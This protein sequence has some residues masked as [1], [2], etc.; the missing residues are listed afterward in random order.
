MS[1]ISENVTNIN[2]SL[3]I[4][5]TEDELNFQSQFFQI[6][7]CFKKSQDYSVGD[8]SIFQ[9]NYGIRLRLAP[10]KDEYKIWDSLCYSSCNIHTPQQPHKL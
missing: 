7:T 3:G 10:T 4:Y 5:V 9:C 8:A 2:S 1:R 6:L